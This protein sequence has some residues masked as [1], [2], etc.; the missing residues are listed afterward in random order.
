MVIRVEVMTFLMG[1][2]RV[3]IFFTATRR[4]TSLSVKMPLGSLPLNTATQP[5][6]CSLINLMVS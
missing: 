1:V 6:L 2:L 4:K 5:A 3:S